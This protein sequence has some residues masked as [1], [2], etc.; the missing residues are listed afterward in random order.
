LG[1]NLVKIIKGSLVFLGIC[2]WCISSLFI[3]A[4][5]YLVH[6][7]L[8]TNNT[9]LNA[10]S[11]LFLVIFFTTL[12]T[13]IMGLGGFLR[14]LPMMIV[15]LTG[16][17]I[18]I[19]IPGPRKQLQEAPSEIRALQPIGQRWWQE[20]PNWLRALTIV[21]V[22]VITARF[23]FLVWALPPFVWDA[24]TYHLT[25]VA[26]WTQRGRIMVFPTTVE[27]IYLPANFEVLMSWFTVFLHHDIVVEASGIL[28]Y[29]LALLA[30]MALGRSLGLARSSTIMA[31]L[32]YASTPGFLLVVT[33]TK[34]DPLV[35]AIFLM[36]IA[37]VVNLDRSSEEISVTNPLG[38]LTLLACAF[39]YGIGTKPYIAHLMLGLITLIILLSLARRNKKTWL[40]F[41]RKSTQQYRQSSSH[42]RVL[43]IVLLSG[44]LILGLYWYVRNLYL[45][46]NP[47]YPIE[48]SKGEGLSL[49]TSQGQALSFRRLSENIRDFVGKFGDKNYAIIP[50]LPNTTGWGWFSY[51][52]GMIS[53]VWAFIRHR[54]LRIL[55]LAFGISLATL[56]MSSP[57]TPFNMR[58]A[59][60]FPALLSLT[61]AIF[62]ESIPHRMKLE[63]GA[64]AIIFSLCLALNILMTLNYNRITSVHFS[65]M[66]SEPV[67]SRDA[68][69]LHLDL[70]A[71]YENALEL[72]PRTE[73]LGFN[74]HGN[75][76]VY[77]L[78]R[79]DFSQ[80]LAFIPFYTSVAE[81]CEMLKKSLNEKDISWL[82]VGVAREENVRFAERCVDEGVLEF[83]GERL[84][85]L[86]E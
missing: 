19:A 66:L 16:L 29:I 23:V 35:V 39:L 82:F 83:R 74:V 4:L 10:V 33:G 40:G 27:R 22:F 54:K 8:R 12:F 68:V 81:G 38:Q 6:R 77:P 42:L 63:R 47:F 60:W 30:V 36:M 24:L 45:E 37:I 43:I 49:E 61:F 26:E 46:G 51:G 18:F 31:A 71:Y 21:T 2:Y 11:F 13:F 75:G 32:A 41:I 73:T 70:P 76:F 62:F 65:R 84:Y 67:M 5:V 80:R 44:A 52:L 69:K 48:V 25:N 72:V 86:R 34:N 15:S 53:L 55:F 50:S 17:M 28:A 1:Y 58:Y 7:L 3:L 59:T 57:L 79:A 85:G 56:F 64:F 20:M 9:V 14:P 78:Y